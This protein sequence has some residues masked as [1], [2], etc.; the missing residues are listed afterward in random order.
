MSEN[1]CIELKR[2][3][4]SPSLRDLRPLES[5]EFWRK[6]QPVL[7]KFLASPV[8]NAPLYVPVMIDDDKELCEGLL[9]FV[10]LG[11]P[12]RLLLLVG[13]YGVGKTS[14]LR[15]FG[16]KVLTRSDPRQ[17]LF[18]WIYIDGNKNAAT[19]NSSTQDL[20]SV[21]LVGVTAVIN[22]YL[23]SV[24]EDVHDLFDDVFNFDADFEPYRLLYGGASAEKKQQL[25]EKTFEDQLQYIQ[26]G[27]RFLARKF[28]SSKVVLVLDNLDPLPGKVQREAVTLA[29]RLTD[30]CDI[31]AI[32]AVRRSTAR[33]MMLGADLFNPY[34]QTEVPS[35]SMTEVIRRRIQQALETP[36]A[37]RAIIGK[38]SLQARV[39]ESPEFTEVLIKG[40]S[41]EGVKR[42]LQGVSNGSVR[43]GLRFAL[44]VYRSHFLDAHR[45]IRKISP[46]ESIAP[47]LWRGHLPYY[48]VVKALMLNNFPVYRSD[49]SWIGNAFGADISDARVAPFLRIHIILYAQ[50]FEEDGVS[51]QD[52][53][54]AIEK[55]L[56]VDRPDVEREVIWLLDQERG[57]LE[58]PEPDRL[59]AT[60]RGRFMVN[61]LIYDTEYLTHIA[62]DVLMCPDLENRLTAPADRIIDRIGNVLVL[63][64][65][66]VR[67]EKELM[68]LVAVKGIREYLETFRSRGLT[69]S[70]IRLAIENL[71]PSLVEQFRNEKP[72]ESVI[73]EA[74]K[75]LSQLEI[76][77]NFS[78]FIRTFGGDL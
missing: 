4:D 5:N 45:I 65:Y 62:T 53:Y 16:E 74:R 40:L 77:A 69:L 1:S 54:Q 27:L 71:N 73:S 8:Y 61:N 11:A 56:R 50:Q 12:P 28:G 47:S 42:L 58:R 64:E 31:R 38:G 30:S 6:A 46:A 2:R 36:E 67:R 48:M 18:R 37:Q 29:D 25:V 55:T 76:E 7:E 10:E 51:D 33:S 57:W 66:L 52:L 49:R 43:D 17:A 59:A 70:M 72:V 22:R 9:D 63:L 60:I 68:Q 32:V 26:V 44:H 75:K 20:I 19:L 24:N 41:G 35:P 78:R 21:V 39:S 14:A 15:F 13:Q 34:Q 3:T 23:A